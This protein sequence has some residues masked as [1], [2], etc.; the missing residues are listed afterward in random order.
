MTGATFY[1]VVWKNTAV[2]PWQVYVDE[3]TE[4][5]AGKPYIFLPT[6]NQIKVVYQG[7]KAISP[8]NYNGLYGTF[9]TI[10]DGP[11]GTTGNILE[12]NYMLSNNQIIKCL[13]NCKLPAYRAYIKLEEISTTEPSLMPGRRRV[14]LDVQCGN[15]ATGVD[16]LTED[17]VV[18]AMEGTYD[19]LGRKM[20][21][22]TNTGFYI[23]NGKKVVIVK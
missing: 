5:E 7:E 1:E 8:D 14:A 9:D 20:N 19:V 15:E 16:N 10:T 18:P 21:E 4:L 17:G 22:P 12:G 2:N 13:G 11:A 6:S 23:V 3:V